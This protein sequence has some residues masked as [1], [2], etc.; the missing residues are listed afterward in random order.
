M[1]WRDSL[2]LPIAAALLIALAL[3]IGYPNADRGRHRRPPPTPTPDLSFP[4]TTLLRGRLLRFN[5]SV[6]TIRTASATYAVILAQSTS[7]LAACGHRPTLIPGEDLEVRVPV[8]GNGVL[9]AHMV[10]P[11]GPCQQ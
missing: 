6:M 2:A 9:L 3:G 5:Q 4:G 8:A 10:R 1:K 11:A 7:V